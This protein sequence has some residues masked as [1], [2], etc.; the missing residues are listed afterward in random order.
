MHVG[1]MKNEKWFESRETLINLFQAVN[2][3]FKLICILLYIDYT[4]L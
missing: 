1:S 3:A 4:E 2:V